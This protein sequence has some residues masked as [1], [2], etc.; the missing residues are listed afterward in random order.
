MYNDTQ[1]KYDYNVV[2]CSDLDT[3]LKNNPDCMN[4][5]AF[6]ASCMKKDP[7]KH[8]KKTKP[9]FSIT[10]QRAWEVA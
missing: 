5:R 4:V 2:I 10:G 9:P 7:E 3:V 6:E 1:L 8:R